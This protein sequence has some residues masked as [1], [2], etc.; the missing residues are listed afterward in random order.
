MSELKELL[1]HQIRI[2]ASVVLVKKTLEELDK[3]IKKIQDDNVT[4]I[5]RIEELMDEQGE[6]KNIRDLDKVEN[7]KKN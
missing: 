2:A 5:L 7:N 4:S 3:L 1:G 6:T